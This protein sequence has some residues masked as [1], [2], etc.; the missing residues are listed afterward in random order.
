MK[1]N[2]SW[3]IGVVAASQDAALI[4]RL[5][6]V[7]MVAATALVGGCLVAGRDQAVSLSKSSEPPERVSQSPPCNLE[8]KAQ[9]LC[10]DA[11]E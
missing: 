8:R 1:G 7:L 5:L 11:T 3:H 9:G 4:G 2:R 6:G 10:D